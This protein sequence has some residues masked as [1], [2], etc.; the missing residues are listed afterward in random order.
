MPSHRSYRHHLRFTLATVGG[1]D[2]SLAKVLFIPVEVGRKL[3]IAKMRYPSRRLLIMAAMS[4]YV[5]APS[6]R[7]EAGSPGRVALSGYDP[8]SYFAAG[9]PEKGSAEFTYPFDGASY[10]FASEEHRR[11]FAADPERYAP[12]FNGHCAISVSR[13]IKIE[14]DPEAWVIWNG[15]LFVFA[16]KEGVP[17]FNT[18]PGAIAGEAKAAWVKLKAN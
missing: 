3:E 9:H 11:M 17:E 10:L 4:S 14:A 6:R 1:V 16:A 12:Q 18:N 5:F 2:A 8:V 13:G 7:A 15:K